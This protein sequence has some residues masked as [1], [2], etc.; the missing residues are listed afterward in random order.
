VNLLLEKL[1][2]SLPIIQAPMAGTSTPAMAAAVSNA[3]GLGSLGVGATDAAG[4]REMIVNVRA[5]SNRA[6]N[7]NLFC[8]KPAVP[9]AA[10]EAGWIERLRP[11][12]AQYGAEPSRQLREIYKSFVDNDEML[13]MLLAER[14]AVASFHF[15]LPSADRIAALRDAGIFLLASATNLDDARAAE[16]AGV[17]AVVAQGYEAGGHRGVFDEDAPDEKLGTMALTRL[18]VRELKIPVVAAG[19]IMD[20]AGIAAALVLGASAVQ[21]G[22]AFVACPESTADE[23]YRAALLSAGAGRT[24]MTRAISGRPARSLANKFTAIGETV[25]PD[26]IAGYPMAYDAGKQLNAAA[27]ARGETGFGAQWAG[28]AAPL[29]RALPAAELVAQ[30]KAEMDAA[31]KQV[32]V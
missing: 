29:A 22:T 30:L 32:A 23:A 6:F 24:S 9:D 31:L 4:A 16:A 7:V 1:R 19:G 14:P 5:A 3:G 21:M 17:G 11:V 28:Q 26:R 27:K 8:H 15:G 12:F 25:S 18:L 20:G 2:I 10:R 13:E